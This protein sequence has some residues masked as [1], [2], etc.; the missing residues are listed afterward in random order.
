VMATSTSLSLSS[1]FSRDAATIET[2]G[3]TIVVAPNTLT[4]NGR[5][6]A[7][8]DAAIKSIEVHV[9]GD[10]ITFLGDGK[11]VANCPR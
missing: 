4:V 3:H 5:K 11:V 8:I 9:E 6:V 1:R 10:A 7:T 2:G